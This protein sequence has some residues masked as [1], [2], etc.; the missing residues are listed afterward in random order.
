M[1]EQQH[2]SSKLE[3]KVSKSISLENN[4]SDPLKNQNSKTI[5]KKR[6]EGVK[7]KLESK[8]VAITGSAKEEGVKQK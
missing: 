2:I 1:E 7:L 6:R 5:Y 8:L 3:Q 4:N